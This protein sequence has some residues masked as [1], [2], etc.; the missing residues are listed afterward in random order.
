MCLWRCDPQ[1]RHVPNSVASG[2]TLAMQLLHCSLDVLLSRLAEDVTHDLGVIAIN[3][4]GAVSSEQAFNVALNRCDPLPLTLLLILLEH[5]GAVEKR[6]F[7]SRRQNL[8]APTALGKADG[9]PKE[10]KPVL[11]AAEEDQM[12]RR[13]MVCAVAYGERP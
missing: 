13:L 9:F 8:S 2:F 12:I 7:S 6:F 3:E 1:R 10:P 11:V 5:I 4:E